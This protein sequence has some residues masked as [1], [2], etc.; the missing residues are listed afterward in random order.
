MKLTTHFHLVLRPRLHG[1]VP[2]LPQYVF[3][4]WCIVKYR[5][6]FTVI[7]I[8]FLVTGG[9]SKL[10]LA[11]PGLFILACTWKFP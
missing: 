2:L 7:F 1:A 9:W 10:A 4:A 11:D 3:M 6:N 5:D 8:F